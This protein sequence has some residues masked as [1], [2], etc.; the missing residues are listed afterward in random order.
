M[1]S[2]YTVDKKRVLKLQ[3]LKN[4]TKIPIKYILGHAI[5]FYYDAKKAEKKS[6]S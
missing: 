2:T 3:E 4:V 1:S 6:S 5:D